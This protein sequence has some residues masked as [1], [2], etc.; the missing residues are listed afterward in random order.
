MVCVWAYGG[1][2]R[3]WVYIGS[4]VGVVVCL[5]GCACVEGVRVH[6]GCVGC[7]VG[8][9]VCGGYLRIPKNQYYLYYVFIL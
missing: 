3:V 7:M 8:V 9:R 5:C 1:C 2:G 6:D 4:M